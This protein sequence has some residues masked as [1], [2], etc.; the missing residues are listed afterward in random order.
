ML[1]LAKD[2]P[3]VQVAAKLAIGRHRVERVV[4][5]WVAFWRRHIR[6]DKAAAIAIGENAIH[7]GHRY[8]SVVTDQDT[9]EVLFATEGRGAH[10]LEEFARELKAH[11]GDPGRIAFITMDMN[12]GYEKGAALCFPNAEVVFDKF[13]VVAHMQKAV[14]E[15]RREE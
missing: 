2:M 12:A 8:V 14:D 15:V 5:R 4:S 9:H 13:H 11:G 10:G 1:D 7:K 3:I 6:M